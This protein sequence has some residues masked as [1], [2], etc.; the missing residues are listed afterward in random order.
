MRLMIVA[1]MALMTGS[2][3]AQSDKLDGWGPLKFGQTHDAAL[4]ALD[5]RGDLKTDGSIKLQTTVSDDTYSVT[6]E[7][8]GDRLQN[9]ELNY[10]ITYPRPTVD[11]CHVQ[12]EKIV[13]GIEGSYGK[14]TQSQLDIMLGASLAH[15]LQSSVTFS[16]KSRLV[17]SEFDSGTGLTFT[18]KLVIRYMDVSHTQQ[19]QF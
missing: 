4:A 11:Q 15:V 18:C 8:D 2:A 3:W 19:R 5:G 6:A 7:F 1:A 17:L 16:N 14:T 9:I 10:N 13:N 12:R